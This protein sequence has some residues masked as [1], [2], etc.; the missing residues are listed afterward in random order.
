MATPEEVFASQGTRRSPEQVFASLNE[1]TVTVG[2]EEK[3]KPLTGDFFREMT[4]FV[5]REEPGIDYQSGIDDFGFRAKLSRADT[6]QE[7][8]NVLR[9]TFG[10]GTFS[11]DRFGAYVVKPEGLKRLGI[12]ADKP[13]A[14]DEQGLSLNDI[15]DLSGD[16]PAIAA[17]TVAGVATGGLGAIPA[18]ATVGAATAAGKALG[19]TVEHF[20]GEN[21]QT[22]G[23]VAKD[24]AKEGALGAAGEGVFRSLLAPLGRKIL[25]P[26][27]KRM[28]GTVRELTQEARA[29]GLKPSIMQI[30]K[31]PILGR[32][33][34]VAD[35]IFG[36]PT[37]EQNS[38]ALNAWVGRLRASAG[39]KA[40]S[41]VKLGEDVKK[42]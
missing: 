30:S 3:K 21:L 34:S 39:P 10:E 26:E 23:E 7:R 36:D 35:R 12:E 2:G 33:L 25:A 24:V 27:A 32:T 11:K 22:A 28:T 29:Q 4:S 8:V 19:E 18:I 9:N 38:R 42:Q 31:P 6:E 41:M 15:A 13:R 17:G 37:A 5:M 40:E 1:P 16:A 20:A 14:I